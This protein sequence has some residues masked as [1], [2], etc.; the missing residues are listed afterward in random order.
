MAIAPVP[1]FPFPRRPFSSITPFTYSD[2]MTHLE[3]L[4]KLRVYA[5]VTLPDEI[6]KVLD[7]Y[8]IEL[9]AEVQAAIDLMIGTLNDKIV[10]IN[11]A[12]ADQQADYTQKISDLT[13]YVDNAVQQ[14]IN[15]SIEVQDPVVAALMADPDSDTGQTARDVFP[16]KSGLPY[17]NI[18]DYGAALD[19]TNDV[20]AVEAAYADVAPGGTVTAPSGAVF[21]LAGLDVEAKNVT[22]DFSQNTIIQT[23]NVTP[24]IMRG[25]MGPGSPASLMSTTQRVSTLGFG[26]SHGLTKGDVV[27]VYS[28]DPIPYNRNS[29]QANAARAGRIG[30]VW[31]VTGNE[32]RIMPAVPSY[33]STDIH[34]A[35]MEQ[36][37]GEIKIGEIYCAEEDQATFNA[38]MVLVQAMIRPRVDVRITRGGAQGVSVNNCYMADVTADVANLADNTGTGQLGYGVADGASS[39]SSY[40]ITVRDARH[41]FTDGVGANNGSAPTPENALSNGASYGATVYARTNAVRN[42]SIDTHHAGENHHFVDCHVEGGSHAFAMRGIKHTI[43]NPVITNTNS[44]F[45]VFRET[46]YDTTRSFGHTIINPVMVDV[47]TPFEF[48]GNVSRAETNY[49]DL[50]IQGGKVEHSGRAFNFNHCVVVMNDTVFTYTGGARPEQGHLGYLWNSRLSG[51]AHF[52]ITAMDDEAGPTLITMIQ[53]GSSARANVVGRFTLDKVGLGPGT[54]AS[55]MQAANGSCEIDLT[56]IG[57]ISNTWAPAG[58]ASDPSKVVR[59]RRASNGEGSAFQTQSLSSNGPL[60]LLNAGDNHVMARVTAEGETRYINAIDPGKYGGQLLTIWVTNN[61]NSVGVTGS[62][63]NVFLPSGATVEIDAGH[64]IQFVWDSNASL[65]RQVA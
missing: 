64:A 35:K 60:T 59:V 8:S 30:Q 46:D 62:A 22:I 54:P 14:I 57:E 50:V 27:K 7:E 37:T 42:A 17:V 36:R 43:S 56:V 24:I 38:R 12:L 65:W 23:D 28:N 52:D 15:D 19:G 39:L 1:A 21:G 13:V 33:M 10:E 26:G 61:G 6:N 18:A 47:A 51:S 4:E 29:D 55:F 45:R 9:T 25:V 20:A 40:H 3:L 2:A 49:P 41:A 44:G 11:D 58:S 32:V 31:D 5:G 53:G 48:T 16:V 34:V 63:A